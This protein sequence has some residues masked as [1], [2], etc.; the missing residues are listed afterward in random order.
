MVAY[1]R[2]LRC[3]PALRRG[4][5]LRRGVALAC[6][7]VRRHLALR[8]CPGLR[9]GAAPPCAETAT[10]VR[11]LIGAGRATRGRARLAPFDAT[12]KAMLRPLLNPAAR[13]PLILPGGGGASQSRAPRAGHRPS[14]HRGGGAQPSFRF[15][16]GHRSGAPSRALP[17]SR[18]AGAAGH[19]ALRTDRPWRALHPIFGQSSQM[20]DLHLFVRDRSA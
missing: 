19:R 4:E 16:R 17:L 5:T 7:E 2:G 1:H 11:R 15:R 13:T 14:E 10:R 6:A 20:R 18:R 8:R 12:R 9:G 3:Q